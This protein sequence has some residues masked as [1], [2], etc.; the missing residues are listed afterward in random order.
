MEWLKLSKKLYF[1]SLK[2]FLYKVKLYVQFEV[3]TLLYSVEYV[4]E[5]LLRLD[6]PHIFDSLKRHLWNHICMCV[7]CQ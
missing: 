3:L 1:L 4:S 7:T 6:P 2:D 5:T